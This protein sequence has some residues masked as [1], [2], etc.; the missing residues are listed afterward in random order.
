MWTSSWLNPRK[1]P[2]VDASPEGALSLNS[3]RRC[4]GMLLATNPRWERP[5]GGF[6]MSASSEAVSLLADPG[7]PKVL[8][9]QN[10][11][12]ES[13]GDGADQLPR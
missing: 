3:D 10:F 1:A 2:F 11:D 13:G 7:H 8:R 4:W 5:G 12:E 6:V 9:I